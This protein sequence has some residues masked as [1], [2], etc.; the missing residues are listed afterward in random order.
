LSSR[1][2]EGPRP[3]HVAG[4]YPV[5][6][7][8]YRHEKQRNGTYKWVLRKTVSAK[9]AN[10]STYTKVTAK[11]SLPYAGKWRIRAHHVADSK[12]AATY[13]SYRYVSVR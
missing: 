10:Y 12:N 6:L 9:A 5:K 3:R 8:C 11:V 13:S 4:T 1:R 2:A 7:Q